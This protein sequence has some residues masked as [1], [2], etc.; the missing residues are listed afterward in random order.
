MGPRAGLDGCGKSHPH[1]DSIP[2]PSC[3]YQVAIP[4]ELSRPTYEYIHLKKN[5]VLCQRLVPHN[6][7]AI[8]HDFAYPPCFYYSKREKYREKRVLMMFWVTKF[9][10]HRRQINEILKTR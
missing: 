1:R 3:P 6:I 7:V 5:C 9:M 10:H 2:G 8:T 4:T